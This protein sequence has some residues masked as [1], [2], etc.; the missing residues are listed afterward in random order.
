MTVKYV[1]EWKTTKKK[2]FKNDL[3]CSLVRSNTSYGCDY[4]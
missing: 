2:K 1:F 4:F 3:N